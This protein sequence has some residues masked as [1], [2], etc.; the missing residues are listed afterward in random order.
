MLARESEVT[1]S[2]G[3][4]NFMFIISFILFAIAVVAS[5]F[6]GLRNVFSSP[7]G[8]KRTLIGVGGLVVVAILSYVFATGTDIDI[9]EMERKTGIL[10]DEST[11]KTIGTFLNMFFILTIVA[12]GAMVIP[13]IKK[14][15]NK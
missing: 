1:I 4:M 6:F 8:L 2:N 5:L 15:F 12:V 11:V 3:S 14:M 7:E 13:G 9:P 10:T